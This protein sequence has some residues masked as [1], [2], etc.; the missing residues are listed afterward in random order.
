ML[1]GK[2]VYMYPEKVTFPLKEDQ[3]TKKFVNFVSFIQ[4]NDDFYRSNFVDFLSSL[5]TSEFFNNKLE[6]DYCYKDIFIPEGM[7]VIKAFKYFFYENEDRLLRECQDIASKIIQENTISGKFCISVHPLDFLSLS[8]NNHKWR[9]CH[10]LDGDYRAGNLSYMIDE[11]TVICYLISDEETILPHFPASVP[12]NNKKWRMLLHFSN[13]KTYVMASR[14]YPF[15]HSELLKWIQENIFQDI[16]LGYWTPFSKEVLKSFSNEYFEDLYPINNSFVPLNTFVKVGIGALNYND[17]L[18]SSCYR[19]A[20][21][22]F[23]HLKKV[24]P[25][26]SFTKKTNNWT[27]IT[28]G[29]AS[30]CPNCG[31]HNLD[32]TDKLICSNCYDSEDELSQDCWCE[33]CHRLECYEDMIVGEMSGHLFCANCWRDLQVE[34]KTLRCDCCG[35]EDLKEYFTV[36]D[37]KRIV[38]NPCDKIHRLWG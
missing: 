27:K 34:N 12:W 31:I 1:G 36:D 15:E 19:P 20:Y 5:S 22:Y 17:V 32:L 35:V 28:I 6:K 38:C 30:I 24:T 37:Y 33:R 14:P 13:D 25:Q 29:K 3:Q 16:G 18:D 21:S 10:S 26:Y 8:E 4:D 9:S 7:K 11:A 2:Y 23:K